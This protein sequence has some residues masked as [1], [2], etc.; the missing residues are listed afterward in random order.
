MSALMMEHGKN[1]LRNM[2]SYVS[3]E[4][5]GSFPISAAQI[6]EYREPRL[7]ANLIFK[8]KKESYSIEN[9]REIFPLLE[10]N[11]Q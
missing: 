4:A 9:T 3:I 8:S 7:M 2:I 10:N 5:N 1:C 11:S 6:K